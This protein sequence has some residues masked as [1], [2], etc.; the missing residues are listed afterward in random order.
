MPTQLR[1][2]RPPCYAPSHRSRVGDDCA[3]ICAVV[4]RICNS[5]RLRSSL[6]GA[7]ACASVGR[8]GACGAGT[9]IRA[10][11]APAWWTPD[12]DKAV[13][14]LRISWS[15]PGA[16]NRSWGATPVRQRRRRTFGIVLLAGL[17]LAAVVP[18]ARA[19][20]SPV[21][22]LIRGC[23]SS[24]EVTAIDG[25]LSI[26]FESDPT[27]GT[28]VCRAAD[29]SVDL[30]RF[31][32]RAYQALHVVKA[33]RFSR[34][35]PWTSAD[36]YTWLV[37]TIDGI[38]FRA[39]I[40][41]SF[42]CDPVNVIDLLASSNSAALF[43]NRWM[44]ADA[45][46]G[47]DDLV[48]LV[49]HET[50]HNNGKPHTCNGVDDQTV[51]ELGAWGVEYYLELWEALYAGT[52]LTSPDVYRSYYRDQHLLKS[53]S[54]YLPRICS[55]PTADLSL[56]VKTPSRNVGRVGGKVS[57]TFTAANAGVDAAGD[58]YLYS[59][60]PIGTELVKATASQGS[61]SAAGG[62]PIACA[63]GP[64]AA[65]ATAT[66]RVVLRVNAPSTQTAIT[67]KESEA[68]FG[69]RVTG[70]V[71]DEITT[72]NSASFSTPIR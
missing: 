20:A 58:V 8:A 51:G 10:W 67:N 70:P 21:E 30:T 45:P 44:A 5:S 4:S 68:A 60:M 71:R 25:D 69:A 42:C 7:L 2:S 53:E 12:G 33:L 32:E 39:D 65:G 62:G 57:Y 54:T 59:P 16:C 29:G 55:R 63:V 37:A 48:A 28:L 26:A 72:N 49:V 36:L 23:P 34:P 15:L 13:R 50:R 35:L 14:V 46:I 40:A 6:T 17:V 11:R 38:R 3:H 56:T 24:A 18:S 66:A 61:C 9:L 47:L 31:E 41:T 19:S 52:F 64:L 27:A 22:D 43:T 1:V